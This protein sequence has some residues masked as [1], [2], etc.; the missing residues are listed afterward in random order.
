MQVGKSVI[1]NKA[2]LTVYIKKKKK[3]DYI[4]QDNKSTI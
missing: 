4:S 1:H 3:K 2:T